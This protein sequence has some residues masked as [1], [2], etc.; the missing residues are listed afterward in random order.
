[1]PSSLDLAFVQGTVFAFWQSLLGFAPRLAGAVLVCAV[2]L[3]AAVVLQRVIRQVLCLLN[4]DGLA[5]RFEIP[6]A[7]ARQGIPL[8]IAK[9]LGW[10][11]KWL[12][13]VAALVTATDI[14]GW[15]QVTTFL[16]QVMLYVPNVL[17]AAG[18]LLGGMFLA[19]VAERVVRS[20]AETAG[21]GSHELLAGVARWSILAFAAMAALDQLQIAEQLIRVLFTGL[22]AML[23]LAGGLA[24]GLGG[25]EHA[26]QALDRLRKD[27][28]SRDTERD[29]RS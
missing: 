11:V 3:A 23:A 19:T 14:L 2:G 28:R 25:K 5:K 9:F 6:Q 21:V 7:F 20:T 10:V 26:A 22:V 24:F 8:D 29:A 4:V 15:E 12:V 18:I 1:M 16:T 13:L 27:M 17:I